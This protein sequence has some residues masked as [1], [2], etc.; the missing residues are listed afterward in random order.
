MHALI[1]IKRTTMHATTA[2][3]VPVETLLLLESALF[4]ED[5]PIFAVVGNKVGVITIFDGFKVGINVGD[6][7]GDRVGGFVVGILVGK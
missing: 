7:E 2:A 4:I 1:I 6:A 5:D 3:I